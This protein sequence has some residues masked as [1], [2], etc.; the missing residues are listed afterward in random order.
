GADLRGADL[1]G[2]V[3]RDAVL[4]DAVLRDADLRHIKADF[5]M[6]L[7]MARKE[8]PALIAALRSGKVNGSTYDGACACLCGTLENAGAAGL[9][10]VAS[11]PAESWFM[12]IRTG[13]KPGDASEGGFRSK[14]ALEWA[15]EFCAF[16]GINPDKKAPKPKAKAA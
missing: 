12:P 16:N 5:W 6:I 13:D 9:P 11:S 10:H 2:A 14:V 3:L 1:S 7:T 4:R 15:I 8:V